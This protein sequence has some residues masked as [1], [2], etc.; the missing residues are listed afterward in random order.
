M[1]T[2]VSKLTAAAM[3]HQ[4]NKLVWIKKLME[5]ASFIQAVQNQSVKEAAQVAVDLLVVR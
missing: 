3:H 5:D 2:G 4:G 1:F